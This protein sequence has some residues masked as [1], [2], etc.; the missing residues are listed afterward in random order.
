MG[1][2]LFGSEQGLLL[3][4]SAAFCIFALGAALSTLWRQ[5]LPINRDTLREP[6]SIQAF[7]AC[8][9]VI[10]LAVSQ[11]VGSAGGD[12]AHGW[13][14]TIGALAVAWYLWARTRTFVALNGTGHLQAFGFVL[15]SFLLTLALVVALTLALVL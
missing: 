5:R 7:I 13:G 14:V 4:R 11:A 9:F 6:F 1:K 12:F 3:T 8:P 15:G 2:L 10:L